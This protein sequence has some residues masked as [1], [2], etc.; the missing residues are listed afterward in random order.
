M[1]G[2]VVAVSIICLTS[3]WAV[4]HWLIEP[5]LLISAAGC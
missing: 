4:C 3:H 2:R 1:I 5:S